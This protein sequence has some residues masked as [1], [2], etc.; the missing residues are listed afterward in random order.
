MPRRSGG[1]MSR[2]S[3]TRNTATASRPAP[4]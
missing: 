3:P 1:G 2:P 4:M